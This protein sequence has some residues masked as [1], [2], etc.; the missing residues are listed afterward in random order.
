[1][2]TAFLEWSW[3]L[4]A[5]AT[6]LVPQIGTGQAFLLYLALGLLLYILGLVKIEFKV[7]KLESLDK[8][9]P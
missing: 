3:N 4:F 6:E 8:F 2:P 5:S 9:D 1:M 7:E